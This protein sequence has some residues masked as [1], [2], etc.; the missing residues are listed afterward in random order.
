MN[1]ANAI[2][3]K[4]TNNFDPDFKQ[5]ISQLDQYLAEQNGEAHA[6]YAPNNKLDYLDTAVIVYENDVPLGCGCFKK[7]DNDSV[8]IK[9][10]YTT[11]AS[12]GKG[13]AGSVLKELEKWAKESG[14]KYAVLE[15]G[16]KFD[17]ALCLYKK[18]GYKV[19]ENYGPYVGVSNSVCMQK[20]L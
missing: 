7:F 15:T 6:F 5:L 9:R 11:I 16:V 10:M 2:T 14:F 19:I 8:E 4:R 13:I 3:L 18:W 20:K 17:D 1:T 12:R